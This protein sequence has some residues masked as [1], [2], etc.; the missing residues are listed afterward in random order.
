MREG[1]ED[2]SSGARR[3]ASGNLPGRPDAG[4]VS[5]I[6]PC[7]NERENLPRLVEEALATLPGLLPEFEL[8]LVDDG[9]ADGTREEAQRLARLDPCVRALAHE[10][11]R[12]MGAAIRT[13]L[14]QARFPWSMSVP[15]DGQFDPARVADFLPHRPDADLLLGC[16]TNR[17]EGVRR[18]LVSWVNRTLIRILFLVRVQDPAWV[19]MVRT[20]L[21]R[22]CNLTSDGFFWETEILVRASRLG[23]H[24]RDVPTACRS[25]EH[26]VST[27]STLR[28]VVRTALAM[29]RF[30]I[31][32][33]R[34]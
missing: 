17:V 4:G 3:E 29:L 13:G 8:L 18:R 14:A 15:G 28:S 24:L 2:A 25:R 19:K 26:G 33:G 9:S 21:A 30:R 6:I 16:R 7:F 11:N 20:D 27:A 10:R 34:P 5:F 12:G 31:A 22:R 23:A 32:G 1:T